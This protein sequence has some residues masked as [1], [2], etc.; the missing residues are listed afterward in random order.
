VVLRFLQQV[1]FLATVDS[2]TTSGQAIPSATELDLPVDAGTITSQA[3][4]SAF[5]R[6]DY[7]D[8]S[9]I[10]GI[11]VPSATDYDCICRSRHNLWYFTGI[12][13]RHSSLF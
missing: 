12:R 5:E 6:V 7:L 13:N 2:A 11:A 9:T 4:P 3:V 1:I 10:A 8:L